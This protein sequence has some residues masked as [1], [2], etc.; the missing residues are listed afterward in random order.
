MGRLDRL[1]DARRAIQQA[2]LT[3][4]KERT[5]TREHN[6]SEIEAHGA[7]A[8]DSPQRQSR[9]LTRQ[10]GLEQARKL[11][12]AGLLPR[13]IERKMGPSIDYVPFA[14]SEAARKAGRPVARIIDTVAPGIQ[15]QGFATGFLI[16]PRLILTNYHVFPSRADAVGTGANF[17]FD[18]AERGIQTGITFELDPEIFYASDE[19]L[20]FAIVAVKS[21]TE[22]KAALDELGIITLIEATPK[23]LKGQPVSII[24]YPNGGPKQYA[25]SQNRL[26]DVLETGYLHYETDTLEGSSGSPAFSQNWELVALH[27]AAIPEMRDGRVVAVDGEFWVEEMGDDRVHWIANEGIRVSAIVNRLAGMSL[28]NEREKAMLRELLTTTTD[29]VDDL[30]D[31]MTKAPIPKTAILES[32]DRVTSP[33]LEAVKTSANNQFIFNAPVTIHIYAAGNADTVRAIPTGPVRAQLDTDVATEASIRFDPN[34]ENR[35]GYDPGFLDPT[36]TIVVPLP[37]IA[38]DRLAEILTDS[39]NQPLVLKYHHFELV[40]NKKRRLQMWS[41]VNVDYDPAK[42]P[43]GDR[44]TFGS[45]K[46]I[47][48]KRIPVEAQIFDADFYKPA[49]NID[50]G[51]IVR[52]E[53]NAWGVTESEIEFAN[54]DT[55]HWTNCTPQH[56]AFNQSAPGRR[57]PTYQGMK[58]LW[59]DFENYIQQS[60]TGNDTKA[61]ILAGPILDNIN[62]PAKNFGSGEIQYPLRFW[63][64]VCV[65]EP[66]V[67]GSADERV[68][69]AFGFILSQKPVVDQFGI[70][71]FGA[72]RFKR[73]QVSLATITAEAGITFDD[74]LHQADTM[75]GE[76]MGIRILHLEHI[77]GV[78]KEGIKERAAVAPTA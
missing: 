46:W 49:G 5:P 42:K 78:K 13:G 76:T 65:V 73:Y 44:K 56:E 17:L 26:V 70:E 27:H 38:H 64:V 58:G 21:K 2:A 71:A 50:R 1:K 72:D 22:D 67:K 75:S 68:L 14:P 4:W 52:R 36:G 61:C 8:A 7:G 34:Y 62:D 39:Q 32:D 43:E 31:E 48:D 23:I 59:G 66:K 45:D 3:R 12:R 29:P 18:Q 16:A 77:R 33:K 28:E 25:I 9:Y 11:S 54:S 57:D 47:A 41:A 53:D 24:Q 74:A 40:M 10:H 69:K 55:F 63:K 37:G 30:S 20:D 19:G 35:K 60:R 15:A 51:H 6:K